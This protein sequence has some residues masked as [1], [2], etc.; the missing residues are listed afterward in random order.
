ML[1]LA[2][3]GGHGGAL[4]THSSPTSE[5]SGVRP[6]TLCGKVGSF[7]NNGWQFIAQ[8][9][10]QLYVLVLSAYKTSCRDRICSVESDIKTQVNI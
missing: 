2:G 4:V 10:D 8:K 1:I 3:G 7:L 9:L 6:W 5:V